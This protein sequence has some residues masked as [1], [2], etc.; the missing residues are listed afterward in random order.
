MAI[1]ERIALMDEREVARHLSLGVQ[2]LRNWRCRHIGPPYLKLQ[3]SVRYRIADVIL[4]AERSRIV[5]DDLRE[6]K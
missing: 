1:Q 6:G 2:T 4:W 5:P 3:R